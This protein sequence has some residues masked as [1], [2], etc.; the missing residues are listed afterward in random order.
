VP[1][2][3]HIS[4][5]KRES[6]KVKFTAELIYGLEFAHWPVSP[7]SWRGK[8]LITEPTPSHVREWV[9][10][11]TETPGFGVRL[12][13]G[14]KSYFVQRK[15]KGSTSDRWV[16]TDQHSL[17]A[18]RDQ[19]VTWFAMMAKML[20]PLDEIKARAKTEADLKQSKKLKFGMVYDQFVSDGDARVEGLSLRPASA[21]DRRAVVNWMKDSV[22]WDTPLVSVD[23]SLVEATFAPLFVSAEKARRAHRLSGEPKK[24]GG[25]A[26]SDVSAAHKS[27]SYCGAAWNLSEAIK[28]EFN[29]FAAWR[30]KRGKRNPLPKVGRRKTSLQTED[31]DGVINEQGVAWLKALQNHRKSE[32]PALA[33]LADYVHM[34]V[35][36]GGRASELALIR[37]Q[38]VKFAERLACFVEENTK[39]KKDHLLP[40]TPWA[41]ESLKARRQINQSLGWPTSPQDFVFPYPTN[42][43][44]RIEDY[45][46]LTRLLLKETGLW[47][48]LHDLRRTLGNAVFGSVQNLG[49]VAMVLGHATELE[50]TEGYL[51][52]LPVLR[53]IY[54]TREKRLRLLLGIDQPPEA[55][56][57]TEHQKNM[58]EAIKAMA[59]QANLTP[60]ALSIFLASDTAA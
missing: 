49:T 8:T 38:D 3:A 46:P 37:W 28:A 30:A 57:L 18:A 32:N 31:E 60:E 45:R 15:R 36:W 50:T 23:V 10:R 58:A 2:E 41:T 40:L 7:V 52:T 11:D 5:F 21:R 56:K 17:K 24:R 9:I 1:A 39:G 14:S 33:L 55:S 43:S 4:N 22:L 12:T 59:K 34:A 53:A 44:G 29:P 26:A 6:V 35:L 20:R 25:G 51:N 42:A 48:R 13:R 19:A 27:L 54:A 47:I 16:L